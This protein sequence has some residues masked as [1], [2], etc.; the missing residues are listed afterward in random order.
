MRRMGLI[1]CALVT[2]GALVTYEGVASAAE[3]P[4]GA[5]WFVDVSG[6]T[7]AGC[8][9]ERTHFEHE[10]GLACA[11]MGT[12]QVVDE[13]QN[14]ELRATLL[15][16]SP[17]SPWRLELRTVEGTLV[18]SSELEGA[19]EDRLREA[20]MEIARDQAPERTLAAASLRDTLGEG[21]KVTRPWT[22]PK[23]S[24]AFGAAGAL[25][26]IE[27]TSA[28]AHAVLGMEAARHAHFTLGLTGLMGGSGSE[29]ARHLRAGL[30]VAFGAPFSDSIV[31]VLFEG[32][33][34]VLSSYQ[35]ETGVRSAT[36]QTLGGA[37]GQGGVVFAIPL[38]G[39]RPYIAFNG[40]LYAQPRATPFGS[41]DAGLAFP[42]F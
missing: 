13:P 22:P 9:T 42:L 7:D 38:R 4:H 25:G 41:A 36:A 3:T 40:G 11:A 28:G 21:D 34:A 14:A 24:L 5:R 19:R 10:V 33:V 35:T 8:E 18:S 26:G 2:G 23:F 20:A 31:G 29:S 30:G 6:G 17:A 12:C 37:Y 32:G 1:V 15:C 16:T 39:I 27:R